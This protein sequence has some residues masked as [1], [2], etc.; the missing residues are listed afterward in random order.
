MVR[1]VQKWRRKNLLVGEGRRETVSGSAW[2][3]FTPRRGG[4]I[5]MTSGVWGLIWFIRRLLH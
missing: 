3:K 4:D 2:K 5:L 1:L